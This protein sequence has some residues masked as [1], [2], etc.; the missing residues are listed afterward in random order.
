M[1]NKEFKYSFYHQLYLLG[2]NLL[3]SIY[4]L[5][6]MIS[7]YT[8]NRFQKFTEAKRQRKLNEY[9]AYIMDSLIFYQEELNRIDQYIMTDTEQ[10]FSEFMFAAKERAAVQ[11]NLEDYY[12]SRCFD[13][14]DL[15]SNTYQIVKY[16]ETIQRMKEIRSLIQG[17]PDRNSEGLGLYFEYKTL[18]S[19]DLFS[20]LSLYTRRQ[21]ERDYIQCFLPES[22]TANITDIRLN[23]SYTYISK[24]I[25]NRR[26]EM[27]LTQQQ[28][29][30]KSGVN[31]SVIAK[32]EKLKQI[33][34]LETLI[35]LLCC[36]NGE[37]L[38]ST[39]PESGK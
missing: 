2:D 23:L 24:Y 29:S 13:D 26:K 37:L 21:K 18:F 15:D 22:D 36:L 32:I 4:E 25:F 34:T 7:N 35:R 28:L 20:A 3:S 39:S 9:R 1:S 5:Y 10:T 6:I 17:V 38:I 8:R 16:V 30:E 11:H 33:P 14:F 19:N 31:R 12:F 27:D